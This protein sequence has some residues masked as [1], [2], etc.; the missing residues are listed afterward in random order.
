MLGQKFGA[1]SEI[2]IPI[3]FG[4]VQANDVLCCRTAD[5]AR[6][7]IVRRVTETSFGV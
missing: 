4:Q 5:C 3:E 2:A 7:V 6:S 1:R